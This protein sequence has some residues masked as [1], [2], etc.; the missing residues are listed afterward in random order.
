GYRR[1]RHRIGQRRW[2]RHK[3]EHRSPKMRSKPLAA[4]IRAAI[5]PTAPAAATKSSPRPSLKPE[6]SL[7]NCAEITWSVRPWDN[8]VVPLAVK[9]RL[10]H[11]Q[12]CHLL[13]WY[14]DA[15]WIDLRIKA[16][17]DT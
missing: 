17:L 8:S 5:S 16:G 4:G 9:L 11:V 10:L 14:F 12:P 15:C 7:S 3:A 2:I 6:V 13:V 1:A